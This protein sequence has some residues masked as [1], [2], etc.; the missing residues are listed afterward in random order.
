VPVPKRPDPLPAPPLRRQEAERRLREAI[1]RGE[2]APGEHLVEDELAAWLGISRTPVRE[3]LGRLAAIGLVEI[4]A[5]RGARVVPLEPERILDLVQV[6]RELVL[7]AQRLAAERATDDEVERLR[8]FH[9][10][11]IA[12]VAASDGDGVER[13]AIGFHSTILA[14]SR[15]AELQRV[16]PAVFDRLERIFRLAFPEWLGAAGVEVDA[17]LLEAIARHDAA[18]AVA[19]S[20]RGWDVLEAN[21]RALRNGDALALSGGRPAL[22]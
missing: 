1:V 14:A 13:A 17:T 10:A 5:S 20:A 16:Y 8:A 3:A 2:L 18:A 19:A 22:G 15:N 7:L 9:A 6:S 12:A 21:V 4:D 11:R